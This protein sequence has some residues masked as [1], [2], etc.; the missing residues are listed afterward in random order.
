VAAHADDAPPTEPAPG[1]A[2]TDRDARIQKW[3]II[4]FALVEAVI[5]ALVLI[6]RIRGG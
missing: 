6:V 3:A 5:I 2:V 4:A 1:P